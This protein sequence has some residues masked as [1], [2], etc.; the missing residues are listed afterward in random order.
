MQTTTLTKSS[1]SG[2]VNES[3]KLPI[4]RALGSLT[5]DLDSELMRYRKARQ[6]DVSPPPPRRLAF[7]QRRKALDLIRVNSRPAEPASQSAQA[8]S[9][10]AAQTGN[11]PQLAATL[12]AGQPTM[13]P[14][15]PR[16]PR[17]A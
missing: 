11:A 5:V 4:D 14:P 15:P 12:P 13:P 8:A 16:N 2:G 17:L 7:R 10:R 1:V 6:G 9:K 3:L